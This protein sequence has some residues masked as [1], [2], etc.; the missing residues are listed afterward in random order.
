MKITARQIDRLLSNPDRNCRAFLFFGPDLG[1]VRS[2]A[3]ALIETLGVDPKDPFVA[4][5]LDSDQ[6]SEDPRRLADE[7]AALPLAGPIRLVLVRP[8]TDRVA[9]PL[10]ET[11]ETVPDHAVIILEAGDL[12]PR[13]ALRK[14]C[15]ADDETAAI[16]CY[17]EAPANLGRF[18]TE[19][20]D[21]SD[22]RIEPPALARFLEIINGDHMLAAREVEKLSLYAESGLIRQE[23]VEQC[24]AGWSSA[25]LDEALFSMLEGDRDQLDRH[26]TRL[27]D[28]GMQPIAMLRGA[29]ALLLQ[30][31]H[32]LDNC[33]SGL[34]SERA[35]SKVRPPLFFKTK[36][37]FPALA[38]QWSPARLMQAMGRLNDAE[39]LSK[40][41]GYPSDAV[42]R[43]AFIGISMLPARS[44]R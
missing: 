13:S 2:R 25:G 35:L 22:V 42:T 36:Q 37:R 44:G 4:C 27:F 10:A 8:A 11:L 17:P 31:H 20:L 41:T 43:S 6:I 38:R 26:L 29:Q 9:A 12:P 23:D 28:E 24:L 30:F 21:K 7:A 16:G 14:L 33:R 15:E 39:R 40:K 34:S 3:K 18:V 1:L 5:E 19:Q 32:Y